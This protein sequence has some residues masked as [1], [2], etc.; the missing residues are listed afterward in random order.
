[1]VV[2]VL[3]FKCVDGTLLVCTTVVVLTSFM[4]YEYSTVDICRVDTIS[5]FVLFVIIEETSCPA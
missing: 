2:F 5:S 4:Y 1:M 3:A